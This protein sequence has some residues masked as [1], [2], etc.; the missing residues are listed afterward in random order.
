MND[1]RVAD[2]FRMGMTLRMILRASVLGALVL[3]LMA[4]AARA[5]APTGSPGYRI[6]SG[7]V[8]AVEV[9][10]RS[11][12]S[13]QFTVNKD[14]QINLPIL[15]TI[16]ASGRTTNELGTDISRR[17]S[18][19]SREIVQ[20][21]V[22]VLQQYR[23]KNFVL[24]AVLLPG[25]FTFNQ[26]PTVWEAISEAGGPA[27]DA[28]LSQVQII[29]ESSMVPT[30]I[31]LASS[32]RS[33]ALQSLPLLQ[34]GETVRVPR[35]PRGGITS[36]IVYVFGAVGAQ[37]AQPLSESSDLVRAVIRSGPAPDADYGKVEIVR[38]TGTRVVSIRVNMRNYFGEGQVAGNPALE[39]GDT[40]FLPR[41]SDALLSKGLRSLG[42]AL[43]LLASLSILT[44]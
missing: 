25:T 40:V 2:P 11:D 4:P 10:G 18:I 20:V 27:E 43:G 42:I 1:S 28:D 26:A 38:K 22:S 36:D 29:S 19:T 6:A 44:D 33:G 37:G 3:V 8:L 35:S 32:V 17:V 30:I 39:N 23:R 7:D 9:S 21:S 24:G 15:G 41:K 16:R 14:G 34:P 13:G 5:Q 12:L 31:D